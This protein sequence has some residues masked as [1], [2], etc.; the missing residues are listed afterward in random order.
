MF[1]KLVTTEFSLDFTED[2]KYSIVAFANC[3]GGKIYVGVDPKGNVVGLEQIDLTITKIR[4]L[5][6]ENIYPNLSIYINYLIETIDQKKILTI[7]IPQGSNRPYYLANINGIYIRIGSSNVPASINQIKAF[8]EHQNEL[9]ISPLQDLTFNELNKLKALNLEQ[10]KDLKIIDQAG[11]YT[12][13]ALWLSDQCE[14][15]IKLAHYKTHNIEKLIDYKEFTGS[16]I[17]QYQEAYKLLRELNNNIF[18]ELA[19]KELLLNCIIHND[20]SFNNPILINI[21]N[22][23]IIFTNMRAHPSRL[24]VHEIMSGTSAPHNPRLLKIFT[25]LNLITSFGTGITS[26]MEYYNNA[27]LKPCFEICDHIFKVTLPAIKKIDPCISNQVTSTKYQQRLSER[28]DEII[29]L[30]RV[31]KEI[32]R[33]DLEKLCNISQATA[34]VI[35]RKLLKKGI[36]IKVGLGKNL[37]YI[38]S[39]QY[40]GNDQKL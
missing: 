33:P 11:I 5:I 3:N 14:H 39:D 17:K 35:L 7:I 4:S 23:H 13:L 27:S 32:T 20:Y 40:I 1:E 6:A 25:S 21:F 15:S 9:Q 2:L 30:L 28:T 10:K 38:L 8:L 22:D 36:L 29:E 16:L 31:K 24:S 26:I 19:L 34:I 18:Y 37:K 12:N